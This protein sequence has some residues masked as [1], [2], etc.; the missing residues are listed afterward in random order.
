M[1]RHRVIKSVELLLDPG[2]IRGLATWPLFSLTSYQVVKRLLA[3]GIAPATILDVGANVGQFAVAAAILMPS[4]AIHSFEPLPACVQR[5][6]RN[7]Q[8]FKN[9]TI[10]QTAL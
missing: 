10:H 2:A 4:A 1:L 9:I 6:R 8:R 7:T 3:K 5:F